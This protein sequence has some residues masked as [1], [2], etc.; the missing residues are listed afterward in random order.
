M[1]KLQY[2]LNAFTDEELEIFLKYKL[3][4]YSKLTQEDILVYVEQRKRNFQ[5]QEFDKL[6]HEDHKINKEEFMNCP[7]C[8]SYKMSSHMV[9]WQI[10][11]FHLSTESEYASLYERATDSDYKK[12]KTECFVCGYL[13]EDPNK[14][15]SFWER[16]LKL[17]R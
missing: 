8:G 12:L 16:I 5:L 15:I 4:T 11:F 10:P 1:S 17:F 7:R 3:K 6:F 13:V 14:R 2:Y 9:K